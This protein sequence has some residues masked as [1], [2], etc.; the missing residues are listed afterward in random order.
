MKPRFQNITVKKIAPNIEKITKIAGKMPLSACTSSTCTLLRAPHSVHFI[1]NSSPFSLAK[2]ILVSIK[3]ELTLTSF[4]QDE[5]CAY[6]F[7]SKN[8]FIV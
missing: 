1:S 3:K 2:S 4:L 7:I 6:N 8:I 5:H